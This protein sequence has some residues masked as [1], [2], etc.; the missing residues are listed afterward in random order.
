MCIKL[1]VVCDEV[2]CAVF[3]RD[4]FM[5]LCLCFCAFTRY[6]Y[7]I[8]LHMHATQILEMY[9]ADRSCQDC[10]RGLKLLAYEALSLARLCVYVC[11]CMPTLQ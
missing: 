8:Y 5:A 7:Y 4:A 3:C 10:S 9:I 11:M 2:S 1:V 6:M